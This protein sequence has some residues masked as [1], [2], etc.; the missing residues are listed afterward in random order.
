MNKP[1]LRPFDAAEFLRDEGDMT[2]YLAAA[3]EAGDADL[4]RSALNDVARK[5]AGEF[6]LPRYMAA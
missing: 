2:P 1:N 3:F 5:R 4:I 6:D